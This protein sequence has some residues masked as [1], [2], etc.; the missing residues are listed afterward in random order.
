MYKNNKCVY[1]HL[2]SKGTIKYVG[3]GTKDRPYSN[4]N[5][6]KEWNL[7]FKQNKPNVVIVENNLSR[8]DAIALEYYMY[9]SCLSTIVNSTEPR[10]TKSMSFEDL[11]EYFYIDAT[12]PSGL[13]LKKKLTRNHSTNVGDIAGSITTAMGKK[14]WKIKHNNVSYLVHRVVY[15]LSSGNIDKHLVINHID[16]D[17]LNNQVIN[18]EEATHQVNSFK[19]HKVKLTGLPSGISYTKYKNKIDGF[20]AKYTP[21]GKVGQIVQRF[22]YIAFG[23]ESSA[24]NAANVWLEYYLHINEWVLSIR[25]I[26]LVKEELIGYMRIVHAMRS[27]SKA[28]ATSNGKWPSR[29]IIKKGKNISCGTFNTREEAISAK[30]KLI[31]EYN[32]SI[33]IKL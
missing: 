21:K 31:E 9:H 12:S 26:E 25:D 27:D 19:K 7:L 15:L 20:H 5:R 16:G 3:S 24:L 6:N 30:L 33:V 22:S 2:D 14:Y 10:P 28:Y 13:R 29:L 17:G 23:S 18:L 32:N 4:S 1:L 11:N 8:A